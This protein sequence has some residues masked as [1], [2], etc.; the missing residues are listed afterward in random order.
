[1]SLT[2]SGATRASQWDVF[3]VIEDMDED[4]DL[5]QAEFLL[6]CT[7]VGVEMNPLEIE[8]EFESMDTDGGGTVSYAEFCMWCAQRMNPL[9]KAQKLENAKNR[10]SEIQRDTTRNKIAIFGSKEGDGPKLT[11]SEMQEKERKM[12]VS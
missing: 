12:Q 8:L 10:W 7:H 11:M 4:E 1:M 3:E 6:A 5:D 2:L 9:T